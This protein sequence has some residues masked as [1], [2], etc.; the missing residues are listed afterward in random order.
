MVG[1][2]SC[3]Q[4]IKAAN[5]GTETSAEDLVGPPGR[6]VSNAVHSSG[7][8]DP[9]RLGGSPKGN[10]PGQTLPPPPS[11]PILFGVEAWGA[12]VR[13]FGPP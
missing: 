3:D 6:M 9:K 4:V 1:V 10:P 11:A 2:N 13:Q 12:R 7:T 5:R 8:G